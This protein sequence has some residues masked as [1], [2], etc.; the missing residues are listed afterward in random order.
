MKSRHDSQWKRYITR[1]GIIAVSRSHPNVAAFI[2][3]HTPVVSVPVK[4]DDAA[5]GLRK[6][7]SSPIP[8]V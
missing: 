8:A 2:P 1:F 5:S 3:A 7:R 6:W 4:R